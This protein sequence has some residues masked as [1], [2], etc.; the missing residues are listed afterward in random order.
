MYEHGPFPDL[1]TQGFADIAP[2]AA[3]PSAPPDTSAAGPATVAGRRPEPTVLPPLG[4]YDRIRVA[5]E[6]GMGV[7]YLARHRATGRLVALKV[8]RAGWGAPADAV[9]RFRREMRVL[10]LLRHPHVAAVLEA[11][12]ADGYLYYTMPFAPTTLKSRRDQFADPRAAARLT[13]KVAR[14]VHAIHQHGIIHRDLKP[15]NVLL[16]AEGEPLVADFGL[17]R[18][19]DASRHVTETGAVLGTAGYMAPEQAAGATDRLTGAVDVWSLGV[20]LYELLTGRPPFEAD[21]TEPVL[22]L[23]R[24]AEPPP[25]RQLRPDLDPALEAVVMRCL[26]RRP[27]DRYPTAAALADDLDRWLAG[28]P[29]RARA[30]PPPAAAAL[31]GGRS[32]RLPAATAAV[33]LVAV[34]AVVI[35]GVGSA[36]A[37]R[38]DTA[39]AAPRDGPLPRPE[40]LQYLTDRLARGQSAEVI[41]PRGWARYRKQVVGLPND[42]TATAAQN[43][44][45]FALETGKT[46]VVE[47]FPEVPVPAYRIEARVGQTNAAGDASWVGL[48]F[49]TVRWKPD[50][51]TSR[52]QCQWR[53][54]DLQSPLVARPDGR[55]STGDRTNLL[56]VIA[57]GGATHLQEFY[58]AGYPRAGG[59][60]AD[61]AK[62]DGLRWRTLT[63]DVRPTGVRLQVDNHPAIEIPRAKLDA[64]Y[65]REQRIAKLPPPGPLAFDPRGSVGVAACRAALHVRSFTITPLPLDE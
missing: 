34:P 18:W 40:V 17:A 53:W 31:P 21:G 56:T 55:P 2:V 26:Q 38:V 24:T 14:A 51:K 39:E 62:P 1:S 23:V 33:L 8:M 45:D 28:A 43:G 19:V 3:P 6:G 32:G 10:Q 13:A 44:R 29:V 59:L 35:F 65:A 25:P 37:P 11:G 64:D 49:G 15:G 50:G 16:T 9:A 48:F 20:I 54:N 57:P 12:E 47:L 60:A 36:P 22:H 42:T 30:V 52:C 27:T 61:P 5:G 46:A 4:G 58:M 63:A 7:V 41:A